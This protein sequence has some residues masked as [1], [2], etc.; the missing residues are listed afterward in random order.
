MQNSIELSGHYILIQR[1]LGRFR[2]GWRVIRE[3]SIWSCQHRKRS[4]KFQQ[5]K[6]CHPS[7]RGT[8]PSTHPLGRRGS[9]NDEHKS[10][11]FCLCKTLGRE[12]AAGAWLTVRGVPICTDKYI[13]MQ[14][15]PSSRCDGLF[16]PGSKPVRGGDAASYGRNIRPWECSAFLPARM[17][18]FIKQLGNEVSVVQASIC[19]HSNTIV[20]QFSFFSCQLSPIT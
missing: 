20:I 16:P 1:W 5:L 4:L 7:G 18:D 12:V 10:Q 3:S 8:Q 13:C 11:S 17:T 6:P 15:L 2:D 19:R 9:P 14:G